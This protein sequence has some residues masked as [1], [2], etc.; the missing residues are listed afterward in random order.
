MS[1]REIQHKQQVQRV[2][3]SK[4]FRGERSSE[5]CW[6]RGKSCHW[7]KLFWWKWIYNGHS[8]NRLLETIV[9]ALVMALVMVYSKMNLV[10]QWTHIISVGG[11]CHIPIITNYLIRYWAVTDS[12]VSG[13]KKKNKKKSAPLQHLSPSHPAARIIHPTVRQLP[14]LVGADGATVSEDDCRFSEQ[15]FCVPIATPRP[16]APFVRAPEADPPLINM[17]PEADGRR[18]ETQSI[19]SLSATHRWVFAQSWDIFPA[20]CVTITHVSRSLC[21]QPWWTISSIY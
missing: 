10:N 13:V 11:C 21:A 4:C 16:S 3:S 7:N 2:Y 6:H 15:M 18:P 17:L 19:C 1:N 5:T 14:S 8:W 12:R 20:L 9:C